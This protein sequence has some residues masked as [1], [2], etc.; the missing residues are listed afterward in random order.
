VRCRFW[1]GVPPNFRQS[2]Q[3]VVTEFRKSRL[4]AG[5]YDAYQDTDARGIDGGGHSLEVRREQL[6]MWV[7]A[8]TAQPHSDLLSDA[9]LP[10]HLNDRPILF[11]SFT[12]E[13]SS[14]LFSF[15][16]DTAAVGGA[17]DNLPLNA[18]LSRHHKFPVPSQLFQSV[19]H[20]LWP[21][22]S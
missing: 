9:N 21:V 22:D 6:W 17:L 19:E 11:H 14:R 1:S 4:K 18:I 5:C 7:A 2:G 12:Y 3:Q 13:R 8:I 15:R 16:L 20:T 10:K